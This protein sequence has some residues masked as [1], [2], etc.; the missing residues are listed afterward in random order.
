[1]AEEYRSGQGTII[2]TMFIGL[3]GIGSRI[4]DRIAGRAKLLPNWESQLRPLTTFVSIDTNELDQH[5]LSHIPEGSRI[6]ISG[7]DKQKVVDYFRKSDNQQIKQWLDEGYQPRAGVKPGAGQIRVESRLGF[8]YHSQEIRQRLKELVFDSLR[9]GITWRQSKPPK[10]YVYIFCTLAGGTGS[11]SFLSIAYLIDA[12][13]RDQEW[14][15]RVIGNFMLSTLLLDKVGPELHEDIHANTYAALKELEHLTK[16]DYKQVKDGGRQSEEFVYFRS[17]NLNEVSKV[18]SRPFFMSFIIDQPPHISL[19]DVQAAIG[20]AAFLQVFTPIIDNLAGELDNYEKNLEGLTRF[21]GELRNVGLGYTQN[22]GAYGAAAM[23]LPGLDFLEYCSLRFAAQ[24]VRSQIT[25]GL[26]PSDVSDDRTRTLAK[27][28]VNYSD[29]KFL[30]MSDE[31]REGKINH[32]FVASVQEMARQDEKEELR[33]GFWYQL[34][35]SVDK[36]QITGTDKETDEPVRGESLLETVSRKLAEDRKK[37]LSEVSIKERAFVFHKEGINQYVE[38]V[39]RLIENIRAAQK[40]VHEKVRGLETSAQEGEVI[41]DLGLEPISERYLAI[42]LLVQIETWIAQAEKQLKDSKK[43]DINEPKVQERLKNELYE[44]LR[45]AASIKPPLWKRPFSGGDEAFLDARDEALEYYRKVAAA[46]RKI[47]DAEVQLK[48]LRALLEYL[49]NRSRQYARL[50]TRMNK[51]VQDLESDAERYRRGEVAMT[52]TFALRVEVLETLDEP[53]QRI[54]DRAYKAIFIEE[55]QYLSTFDRKSLAETITQELKPV[56][57]SDGTVLDKS[58]EQLV[59]DLRRALTELGRQQMRP[60]IMGDS[61]QAGLTLMT[62]LEIE[63]RLMVQASKRPGEV[64]TADEIDAYRE[65]KF[66]ALSQLIDV[67]ARITSAESKALDDGVTINRTRQ[68]IQGISDV[69]AGQAA[70]EFLEQLK[71]MLSTSGKQVKED[72]W[73]DPRLI[74]VHDVELPIPLYYWQPIKDEIESA[75]V[76]QAADER[77]SYNLHT[78]KNWEYALPNLNPKGSELTIGWSLRTLAEGL[79]TKVFSFQKPSWLWKMNDT[80]VEELGPTLSNSLYH[81]GEFHRSEELQKALKQ[82]LNSA[83]QKLDS[84]FKQEQRQTW[85]FRF[86]KLLVDISRREMRGEM[87]REDILERPILRTL[88]DELEKISTEAG[89]KTDKD[90]TEGLYDGFSD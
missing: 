41:I 17:D 57:R 89:D 66:R 43:N 16:L 22:F 26:D 49:K 62:G 51:L 46:V 88:K 83:H 30:R 1:M 34:V 2:P 25:F 10:Y 80:E 58:V 90:S 40:T 70:V 75:Y 13:I 27:L 28:A 74:I 23:V 60:R 59:N 42:R 85:I 76:R 68:L 55:G 67:F 56:I 52:P 3:G 31:A 32:S 38:L 73:H 36:G 77:R 54:W 19:P 8:F 69:S 50:S 81:I 12:I 65:K 21:P 48:Q 53:R 39:S 18:S 72:I 11:G 78:D 45:Q 35:E 15:P 33:D 71:S 5:R 84:E 29:P 24:A 9:P 87:T 79:I 86:E 63:A 14:H 44:S 7:F 82:Q 6:N 64:V 4:V 47:L 20:D 37:L 61:E